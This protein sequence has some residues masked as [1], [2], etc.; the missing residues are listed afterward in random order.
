VVRTRAEPTRLD[1]AGRIVIRTG[2]QLRSVDVSGG[3]HDRAF[4]HGGVRADGLQALLDASHP[5]KLAAADWARERLAGATVDRETWR[6][7]G[8]AGLF[9]LLVPA[10]DGGLDC[11]AVEALLTF[12][13]LGLGCD[14]AGLV[15]ALASQVFAFGP[16]F[17]SGA[18]HLQRERFLPGILDGSTFGSFAM[19]EPDAGSDS[20]AITTTARRVDGGY[21]LD[22]V[23]TW[24][25]LGPVADLAIVFATTDASKGRWGITAF[26][27]ETDRAG[28]HA[29][30]PIEKFGLESSPFGR[31]ELDGVIV[32]EA[33]RLGPEGAGATL[34]S[35][36]VE[37]ERAYLYAAQVGATQ[38]LLERCV[39]RAGSRRQFGQPIGANQAVSHPLADIAIQLEMSRLLIYKAGALADAGRSVTLAAAMA[40]VQVSETAIRAALQAIQ[41]F[42]AEGYTSAAGLHTYLRDAVGG[43]AYSGTSDIQRNIIVRLLGA[44]RPTRRSR[45]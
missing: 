38:R 15:F 12:E 20:S 4:A 3:A 45:P 30:A 29:S 34:F 1:S 23:K 39:E 26:L 8:H 35:S 44:D 22:G 43:M 11:S 24:V 32:P 28:V 27:V 19:T 14:D 36:A 37:A 25:T 13:G 9:G 18:D 41:L 33:H 16:A 2:R 31:L 6:T 42:G 10:S 21:R 40:K 7:C 5:R 17:N